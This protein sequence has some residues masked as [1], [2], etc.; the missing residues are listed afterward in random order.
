M[1]TYSFVQLEMPY[2]V[3]QFVHL[4]NAR[5]N[6]H[7]GVCMS[8]VP[9]VVHGSVS[10]QGTCREKGWISLMFVFLL[11][12]FMKTGISVNSKSNYFDEV[13]LKY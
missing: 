2:M 7:L 6:T 10:E 9:V 1:G 8:R 5:A 12:S 3:V 11:V 13:I 4:T